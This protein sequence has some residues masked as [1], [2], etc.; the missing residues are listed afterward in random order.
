MSFKTELDELFEKYKVSIDET[1]NYS[2]D[3]Y[4]NEVSC[5]GELYFYSKAE[6]ERVYINQLVGKR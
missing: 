2:I 5:R 1:E 6:N 4:G 3:E